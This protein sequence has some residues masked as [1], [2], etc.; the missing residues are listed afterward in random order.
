MTK[1]LDLENVTAVMLTNGK[2]HKVKSG[3]FK[4]DGYVNAEEGNC[5]R[6]KG[7][8]QRDGATWIDTTTGLGLACPHT[9]ITAVEYVPRENDVVED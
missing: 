5:D 1:I 2:W 7:I 6:G 9:S 8:S 4:V 3:S